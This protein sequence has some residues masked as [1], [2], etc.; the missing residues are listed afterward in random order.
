MVLGDILFI[1]G[2]TM[3]STIRSCVSR[4]IMGH[5]HPVFLK[6]NN[7]VSGQ[8]VWIYLKVRKEAV[9]PNSD[10]LLQIMVMPSFYG[11]SRAR[12][13][14]RRKVV[15]P[16]LDRVVKDHA[17]KEMLCLTL[18]GSIVAD[19]SSEDDILL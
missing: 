8:R 6:P 18:D 9:F 10:G 14:N 7:I 11:I 15:S 3:P 2:H 16:I 4:I 17:I 5:V 1:H 19:L 12:H 13:D